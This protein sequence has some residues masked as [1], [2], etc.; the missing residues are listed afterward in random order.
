MMYEVTIADN[1]TE[2]V[3]TVEAESPETAVEFV[4]QMGKYSDDAVCLSVEPVK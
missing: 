1:G 3:E 4:D 2:T